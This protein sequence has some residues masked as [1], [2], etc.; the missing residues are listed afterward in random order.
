MD[1]TGM[2]EHI[3]REFSITCTGYSFT[4]VK[5]ALVARINELIL[6]DLNGLLTI[7]YRL[8]IDEEKLKQRLQKEKARLSGYAIAELVLERQLQKMESRKHFPGN[9]MPIDKNDCW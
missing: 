3:E 7:L 4:D 9:T 8:D 6:H 2:T 1:H 5:E